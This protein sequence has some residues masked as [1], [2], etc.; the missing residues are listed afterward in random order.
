MTEQAEEYK[1]T[2]ERYVLQAGD[3][4]RIEK[5]FGVEE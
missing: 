4:M 3:V 2:K 1:S 5:H